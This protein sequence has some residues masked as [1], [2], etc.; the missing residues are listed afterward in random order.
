MAYADFSF[1]KDTFKGLV[2]TDETIFESVS[3]RASEY[4]DVVTFGRINENILSNIVISDKIKR[5]CCALA[6]INFQFQSYSQGKKVQSESN[7]KYSVSYAVPSVTE[8][9]AGLFFK[10]ECIKYLGDTGLMY[11]GVFDA[12]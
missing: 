7:G 4:I 3:E 8:S 10:R 9:N 5:C 11:R 1:Y 6:E 2:I 12:D